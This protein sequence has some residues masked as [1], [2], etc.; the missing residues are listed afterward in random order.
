MSTALQITRPVL[1]Y[2]GGKWKLAPWIIS[3]FPEHRVYVE[4]FGG[5]ASVLLRKERSY[6]EVYNDLDGEIVN[7]FRVLRNPKQAKDLEERL[8][9]TPF[10]RRE[11]MASYM[12]HAGRV[13]RARRTVVKSHMGFGADAIR[14]INHTGFRNDTRRSGGIPAHDWARLPAH[15]GGIADRFA[16]VIVEQK[17][18]GGLIAKL[19]GTDVLF[20]CDPP[21]PLS[22]RSQKR[23]EESSFHGYLHEMTDDQHRELA[24]L[25]RSVLGMVVLSGYPCDLYDKELYP[26]WRRFERQHLADGAKKRT[27]VLWL[28]DSAARKMP[29][30]A[31]KFTPPTG[32]YL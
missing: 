17:P 7:L 11:F 1:R 31:F 20:Y 28:N 21:Y 22:T 2:H 10:S 9:L 24:Q 19:D 12:N 29:Q 25:L 4:P 16:G 23:K 8:R 30:E 14:G 18:A 15:I 32:D 3:H 27:E 6:A 26:D 13:E 5:G